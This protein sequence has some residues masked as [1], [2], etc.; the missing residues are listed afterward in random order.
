L[1]S[2]LCAACVPH[3]LS[4]PTRRSSDLPCRY[5]GSAYLDNLIIAGHNYWGHFGALHRLL[6]GDKIQFTDAAGNQ[7]SYV[8][9]RVEGLPGSRSAEPT[10]ELQ[11]RFDLGYRLS[12]VSK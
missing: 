2:V 3:S 7:F 5:V 1:Y 4:F 6:A 9:S 8:V 12:F 10:S 11:S